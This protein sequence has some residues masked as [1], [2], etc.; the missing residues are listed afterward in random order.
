MRRMV[1]GAW[2]RQK[3]TRNWRKLCAACKKR[4]LCPLRLPRIKSGVATSPAPRGRSRVHP[5]GL[6]IL[7]KATTGERDAQ[8][9]RGAAEP[10]P[11][12]GERV[13]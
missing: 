7:C 4:R 12:L 8:G 6:A 1:E 2:R 13:R 9:W 10:Y 3:R 11:K 5:P